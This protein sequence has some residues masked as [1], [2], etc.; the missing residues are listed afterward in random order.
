MKVLFDDNGN[1][2]DDGECKRFLFDPELVRFRL[3]FRPVVGTVAETVRRLEGRRTGEFNFK[4]DTDGG[5][6]CGICSLIDGI[7][8]LKNKGKRID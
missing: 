5:S 6:I 3:E 8:E 4:F 7:G 1:V 2:I